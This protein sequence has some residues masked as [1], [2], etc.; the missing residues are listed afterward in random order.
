MNR[1]NRWM[2]ARGCYTAAEEN[3]AGDPDIRTV[4]YLPVMS[5]IVPCNWIGLGTMGVPEAAVEVETADGSEHSL[6]GDLDAAHTGPK[7]K[8]SRMPARL[9]YPMCWID[10]GCTKTKTIGYGVVEGSQQT[11]DGLMG[12]CFGWNTAA[13]G[14]VF[15]DMDPANLAGRQRRMGTNCQLFVDLRMVDDNQSNR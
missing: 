12:S 10:I 9:G 5:E 7:Q 3:A 2:E 8:S 4:V 15:A 14:T 6:L 11:V 13:A 1:A